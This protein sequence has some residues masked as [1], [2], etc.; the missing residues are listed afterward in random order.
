MKLL[1]HTINKINQTN[2]KEKQQQLVLG[3]MEK[4]RSE[5]NKDLLLITGYCFSAIIFLGLFVSNR[6]FLTL[7]S[8]RI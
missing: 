6:I 7:H 1:L 4:L 2:L 3:E 5:V 8:L